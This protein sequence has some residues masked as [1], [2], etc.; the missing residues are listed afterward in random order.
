MIKS[1]EKTRTAIPLSAAQR[2]HLNSLIAQLTEAERAYSKAREIA[3]GFV[4]Y[5]SEE[6]GAHGLT[7][8]QATMSFMPFENGSNNGN[9][10]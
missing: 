9:D 7:F 10:S 8:D 3:Q 4:E 2:K 6:V 1:T 5:C